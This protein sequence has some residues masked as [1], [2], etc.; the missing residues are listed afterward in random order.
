[1]SQK[2]KFRVLIVDNEP[3]VRKYAHRAFR[4]FHCRFASHPVAAH[5]IVEQRQRKYPARL[6]FDLLSCD[7]HMGPSKTPE[8]GPVGVHFMAWFHYVFPPIPIICHSDDP[9]RAATIP[10]AHFVEKL[11]A[12]DLEFNADEARLRAKAL[13]LLKGPVSF[14]GVLE[15]VRRLEPRPDLS[16]LSLSSALLTFV[17]HA[18]KHNYLPHLFDFARAGYLSEEI[19]IEILRFCY[20]PAAAR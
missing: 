9:E 13:D 7:I 6:P 10:F 15:R 17:A 3:K 16:D 4:D 12:N 8:Y 18:K 1:M 11:Y 14:D 19:L 20:A 5:Q 2:T